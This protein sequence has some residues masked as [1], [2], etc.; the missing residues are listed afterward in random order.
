MSNLLQVI[1]DNKND[2]H[3]YLVDS[4]NDFNPDEKCHIEYGES[5]G[6]DNMCDDR[7]IFSCFLKFKNG[8]GNIAM[9]SYSFSIDDIDLFERKEMVRRKLLSVF[10]MHGISKLIKDK[11]DQ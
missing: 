6:I 1:P 7:Y 5:D 11:L 9:E 10:M 8:T 2:I 4:W 3:F